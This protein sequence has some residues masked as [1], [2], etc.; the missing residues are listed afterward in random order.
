M[1][2]LGFSGIGSIVQNR[3]LPEALKNPSFSVRG[4]CSHNFEKAA[5]LAY[6]HGAS[7]YCTLDSMLLDPMISA[8]VISTPNCFH[9]PESIAAMKAGKDVL[10]EKPMAITCQ[11]GEKMIETAHQTGRVLMIA[12]NLRLEP[13]IQTARRYLD[14][15][16]LGKVLSFSA[17]TGNEGPDFNASRPPEDIWFF[18][19]ALAGGGVGIEKESCKSTV[20][21]SMLSA[22]H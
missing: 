4:F 6:L 22:S 7:A 10:C 15:G 20:T 9:A 19:Q 5:R 1:I 14:S 11:Q 8:V 12:H 21:R 3:H 17:S 18:S 2:T 16:I 13:A